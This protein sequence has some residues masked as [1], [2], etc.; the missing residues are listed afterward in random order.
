MIGGGW[1][2]EP[3]RIERPRVR[4]MLGHRRAAGGGRAGEADPSESP[5]ELPPTRSSPYPAPQSAP[6]T[7]IQLGRG[8][9]EDSRLARRREKASKTR[10]GW[11]KDLPHAHSAQ[12]SLLYSAH[13]LA[14]NAPSADC[15]CI[16]PRVPRRWD[17]PR[18]LKKAGTELTR[19]Q[20][21]GA[22]KIS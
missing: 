2:S 6:P 14:L 7:P 21:S 8:P 11:A 4:W 22:E 9:T 18:R 15:P 12:S 16:T 3:K 10:R 20:R 17:H 13:R 19:S 5:N 1:R